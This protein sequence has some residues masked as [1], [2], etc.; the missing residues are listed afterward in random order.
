M[1]ICGI[2]YLY[3][4]VCCFYLGYGFFCVEGIIN[5]MYVI[6]EGGKE[7]CYLFFFGG[8][9]VVRFEFG[10]VIFYLGFVG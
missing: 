5:F 8:Y 1:R 9:C 6:G 3:V 4:D 2:F 7:G 10:L